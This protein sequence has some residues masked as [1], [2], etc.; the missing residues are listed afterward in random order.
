MTEKEN[1][2][3]T[4]PYPNHGGRIV[5]RILKEHGIKYVF[6]VHGGHVWPFETGFYE[7]G[8][9][10][11]HLR[12]EQTGPYAAEAYARCTRTPGVCYGTAG[13]GLTNMMSG[14]A[15]A[16]YNRAPMVVLSGQHT[17]DQLFGRAF[18]EAYPEELCKSISKWSLS[19]DDW[20]NIPQY[21]RK[22]LH[23][24]MVYPPRP[25]VLAMDMKALLSVGSDKALVGDMPLSSIAPA[26]PTCGDPAAVEKAVRML[27]EAKRPF[28]AAGEGVHWADASSE[29]QE[30]VELLN[31]P[32]HT[33]R[34]ARGAV[35]EDH[36][37]AVRAGY[38]ARFW[39]DSDVIV[40]MGLHLG[41][42]EGLGLPP[43]YPAKAKRIIIHESAEDAW[44]PLPVGLKII[45]NPKMVLRQMID[46]AKSII[47]ETPKRTAWIDWLNKCR[48]E[49]TE[50]Q[51]EALAE[52]VK[53][54]PI[55]PVKLA[56]DIVD[57]LD[58]DATIVYDAF[59]G[60]AFLTDRVR[61]KFSGQ[62]MDCGTWGGVG[63]GIGMGIGAQLAR[64][65]KQVL[66]LMG[67]GGMGIGGMDIETASRYKLP[68]VYVVTNNSTWL[69][70]SYQA[71]FEGQ[72][73]PWDMLPN[74]DYAKMFE[75]VGC[76]GE[77]VTN[78]ADIR[79][80]L[81]RAFNSGKTSVINVLTDK[82]VFNPWLQTWSMTVLA[83]ICS[84]TNKSPEDWCDIILKGPSPVL[85]SN[86]R[87]KGHP[88]LKP[89][90]ASSRQRTTGQWEFEE[91][92]KD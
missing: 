90:E 78:P 89:S 33:R 37:L 20:T 65:G 77:T 8:I 40:I 32:V 64:P 92:G 3:A 44:Q 39:A 48:E 28:V 86:L 42:L 22:A 62:I 45:G 91:T 6:G 2:T 83:R 58:N 71:F 17:R 29:L 30:F 49:H 73:Y 59:A 85:L 72:A 57:F 14:I 66:V 75:Q 69:A 84:D 15:Q 81:D 76:Y 4:R 27:L 13:P 1:K 63:H 26:S 34:I 31:I 56:Q 18:Q 35:S 21:L 47:K 61:A 74:I 41:G 25:I 87:K 43:V 16:Y 23:D 5:G 55:H 12:H 7:F 11:L 19:I 54:K 82:R 79:P 36:P 46:C 38:R 50:W 88:L 68:V 52:Y 70:G 24:C 10:R 53:H 80:A 60:T 51:A 67:D 9:E